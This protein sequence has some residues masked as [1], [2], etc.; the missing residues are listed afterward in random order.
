MGSEPREGPALKGGRH[1]T[2]RQS[3]KRDGGE[4]PVAEVAE[5]SEG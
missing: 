1:G 3:S 5:V 2:L 4:V